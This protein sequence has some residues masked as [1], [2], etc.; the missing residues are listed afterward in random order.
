L[1]LADAARH[2]HDDHSIPSLFTELVVSTDA[3]SDFAPDHFGVSPPSPSSEDAVWLDN[4]RHLEIAEQALRL[5]RDARPKEARRLL[6]SENLKWVR[7]KDFWL[8]GGGPKADTDTV[9]YRAPRHVDTD[10]WACS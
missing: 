4:P 6:E 3:D 2:H 7:D 8:F 1:N 10:Q 5:T 9:R